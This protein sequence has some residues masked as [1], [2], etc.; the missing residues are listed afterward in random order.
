MRPGKDPFD[1]K[2]VREI[3]NIKSA[4]GHMEGDYGYLRVSAFDE[5][6]TDEAVAAIKDLQAKNPHIKGWVL[7]LRNNP[8]GLLDQAVCD[9]Q[10]VP[11]RRRGGLP[12]RPRSAGHR[13]L[14][15]P[16]PTA[17]C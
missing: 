1:V 11:R 9:L 6:A 5:K 17:T 12:A 8:G 7:D 10:P 4:K 2:L 16:A 15:R 14:Q 13:A 3:I